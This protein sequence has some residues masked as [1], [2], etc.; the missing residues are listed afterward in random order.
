[1]FISPRR[2]SRK[3]PI[4]NENSQRA[5]K[6]AKAFWNLPKKN[7]KSVEF[8]EPTLTENT[9]MKRLIFLS[10]ALVA[11]LCASAESVDGF[12]YV[13]L[14]LP[15]GLLW[16]T[17]NIGADSPEENGDYFAWGA[18][19]SGSAT[20]DVPFRVND[21][22]WTKYNATDG[23]TTLEFVNDAARIK[24][25][26]SWRMPTKAEM[27]ELLENCD[28]ADKT[29]NEVTVCELTSQKNGKTILM[30]LAGCYDD[31]TQSLRGYAGEFWT[32]TLNTS[33]S[34]SKGAWG[35]VVMS[36][37]GR[38]YATLLGYPVQGVMPN[39][40]TTWMSI[41][42]VHDKLGQTTDISV[43]ENAL[44]LYVENGSIYGADEMQIF[45]MLGRDVTRLNGNLNGIYLVK[46]GNEIQKVI[47]R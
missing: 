33:D 17:C 28:A 43:A 20:T 14:G 39:T 24:W 9:K 13:D 37:K 47:V 27:Q 35:G 41:R 21:D 26:G 36:A 25:G 34:N 5:I 10:L 16:A 46:V 38:K 2:V 31:G 18:V 22:T 30:P 44:A 8:L 32:S 15:S 6:T 42:P 19:Q 40:R 12:D 11:T 3:M 45:D 4:R 7:N 1:M 23:F 29:V